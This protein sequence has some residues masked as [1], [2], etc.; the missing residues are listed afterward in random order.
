M[1]NPFRLMQLRLIL[2]SD[3]ALIL[4]GMNIA[5]IHSRVIKN[6]MEFFEKVTQVR[7]G[8]LRI[9]ENPYLALHWLESQSKI[10]T[11]KMTMLN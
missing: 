6:D 5:I 2:G 9:F 7:G 3:V 4:K 8:N 11:N 10:V 1:L